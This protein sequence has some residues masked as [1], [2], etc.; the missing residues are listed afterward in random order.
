MEGILFALESAHAGAAGINVARTVQPGKAV[1][2]HMSG[3]GE[4]DL[5]IAAGALSQ[6]EWVQFLRDEADSYDV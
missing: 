3:R 5:F 2:I 4:K 6:V 1:I